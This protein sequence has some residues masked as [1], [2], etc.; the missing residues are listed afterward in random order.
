[1]PVDQQYYREVAS[2]STAEKLLIAAR[3]RIYQDFIA[4]MQPSSADEILDV[5]VSDVINDGANVLE[6]S[7]PHQHKITACGLGEG[8]RFKAAFPL[9][10]Y[11]QIE[12]N[13]RLPFDDNAFDVATSNA[14]LEHAG[15]HENQV[16][17]V[18]ELGRV[19]RRV[20]I[21]V[22]NRFFPVEHHTA[23]PLAHYLDGTF[24]IACMI[25]GKSEWTDE[26]NL[27]LMTR[28]RLLGLA[29]LV[30]KSASAKS[31][32]PKSAAVGYTG[33]SLGLLS[34]NLYLAF[35]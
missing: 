2:G 11:V 20:F 23:I 9:C 27:I 16:L 3:D 1:M 15:S 28:K 30:A 22:P 6:R 13:T 14:V 21:T 19:A 25:A 31:S 26:Q 8:I 32:N 12:P 18:E 33:L 29:A 24:R 10:R 7:Y 5:G 4:Q 35:R 34:S 17:L